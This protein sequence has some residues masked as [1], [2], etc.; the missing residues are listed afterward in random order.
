MNEKPSLS[1][2]I[3]MP[4]IRLGA[5]ATASMKRSFGTTSWRKSSGCLPEITSMVSAMS[6]T[7]SV[8]GPAW[9]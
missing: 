9:S 2:P 3:V 8:I 1:R 5:E 4:S 7:L 6:S